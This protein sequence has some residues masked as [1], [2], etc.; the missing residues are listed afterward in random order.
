[1]HLTVREEKSLIHRGLQVFEDIMAKEMVVLT[2]SAAFFADRCVL[3]AVADHN[4]Y[5]SR[6]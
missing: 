6:Q 5:F 4:E 3:P 2:Q 1:M